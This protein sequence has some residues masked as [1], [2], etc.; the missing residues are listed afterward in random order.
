MDVLVEALLQLLVH[1]AVDACAVL[2]EGQ[3]VVLRRHILWGCV[4]GADKGASKDEK[5][6][7][8]L[9]LLVVCAWKMAG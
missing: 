8:V 5:A 9:L 6:S 4:G 7:V 2:K 3:R 1:L